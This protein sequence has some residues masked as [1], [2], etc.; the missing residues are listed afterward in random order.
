MR[1]LFF[2]LLL[3]A[4][5]GCSKQT[6]DV[7][8][9]KHEREAQGWTFLEVVGTEDHAA[10]E[11]ADSSSTTAR[12]ISAFASNGS[13]KTKKEYFQNDSL[14]LAVTMSTKSGATYSLVFRR[15]KK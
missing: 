6:D 9:V 10:I 13:E 7:G 15:P 3:F 4:L 8:R 12:S 11:V 2:T 1:P 5:F 14:Y